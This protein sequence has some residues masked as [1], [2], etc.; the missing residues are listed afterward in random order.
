MIRDEAIEEIRERRRRMIKE[1]YNGSFDRLLD[2]AEKW[3]KEHPDRIV[4]PVK[5]RQM[6]TT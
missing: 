4:H 3:Q 6:Q 5:V 2:D 1:Q